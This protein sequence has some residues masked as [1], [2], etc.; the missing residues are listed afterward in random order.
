MANFEE[1][2]SH[3][4][5]HHAATPQRQWEA[6]NALDSVKSGLSRLAALGHRFDITE[7]EELVVSEWPRMFYHPEHG[8]LV[9]HSLETAQGLSPGW[10]DKPIGWAGEAEVKSEV[11]SPVPASPAPVT[12]DIA[13]LAASGQLEFGAFDE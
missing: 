9:V 7:A 6:L 11:V 2:R 8:E 13:Q 4:T 3:L 1:L 5:L 10:S 12:V